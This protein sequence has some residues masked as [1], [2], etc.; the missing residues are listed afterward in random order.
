[1]AVGI[2]NARLFAEVNTA[3]AEAHALQARYITQAWS[4]VQTGGQDQ[5]WALYSRKGA[6]S[7]S[8]AAMEEAR[9]HLS[10]E[11]A[12]TTV[13]IE[14]G[15]TIGQAVVA[16]VMVQDIPIGQMQ[17]H[18]LDPSRALTESELAMIEAVIDQV[19]QTAENLRLFDETRRRAG[20]EQTIREITEKM[21]AASSLEGLVKTTAEELGRRFS[22]QFALVELGTAEAS[23]HSQQAANGH[24]HG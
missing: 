6:A 21:R 23:E 8:E 22:A 3:L 13:A 1:V 5:A 10:V 19:A 12:L 18:G 15:Q 7:L 4:Q 2:R 14:D 16:P 20:R 9:N 17:I 11:Q 24:A